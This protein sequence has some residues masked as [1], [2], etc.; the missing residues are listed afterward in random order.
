VGFVFWALWQL[1]PRRGRDAAKT[2]FLANPKDS[3]EVWRIP[4]IQAKLG[5]SQGHKR[6]LANPKDTSEAYV[7]ATGTPSCYGHEYNEQTGQV[8]PGAF[9]FSLPNISYKIEF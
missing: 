3:S 8:E 4:R 6:S 1:A 9:T 7:N 2:Q 5:E